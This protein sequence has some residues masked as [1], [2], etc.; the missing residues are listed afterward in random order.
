MSTLLAIGLANA[1]CAAVLAVPA[2]LVGRYGRRPALA[3]ALWLLVLLKLVTPPVVRPTL[4]WLP[5]EQGPA[6]TALIAA[7][8]RSVGMFD[9]PA[10]HVE[11]PTQASESHAS[12]G[13]SQSYVNVSAGSIDLP[14]QEAAG[15][16]ADSTDPNG[17]LSFLIVAWVVGA[18][19]C[20]ARVLL[21][22]ARFHR[23]LAYAQL[24]PDEM[25]DQARALARQMGIRH[26]PPVWLVPGSLP[27]MVWGVGPARI[28]F[29]AGLLDRLDADER[30]A[31]LAHELGHVARRDHMVR[32]LELA[33]MTVWWWF[34]LVWWARRQ[35]Q[36]REEEC[37]DA[38]AAQTVSARVYAAAI[39][40]TVDFLANDR[41][42]VPSVACPLEAAK[43]L[44]QR[45]LLIMTQQ[46]PCAL[47]GPMRMAVLAL[48]TCVAPLLPVLASADKMPV[49]TPSV[50]KL[51]DP[52]ERM[53]Q[54]PNPASTSSV[55][56][57]PDGK[58]IAA[59]SGGFGG[60]GE[61]DVWDVPSR[62]LIW[63]FPEALGIRSVKFTPDSKRLAWAGWGG[64]AR[65]ADLSA[66]EIVFKLKLESGSRL[67]FSPDQRWLATAAEQGPL[68][69]WE[70]STGR[71]AGTFKGD[72]LKVFSF[73]FSNDSRYL[74]A[75]GVK[76]NAP[77]IAHV[78]L[79]YDV[80][81]RQPVAKLTGHVNAVLNIAF[82]PRDTCIATSSADRT[83]RIWEGKSF[84][85]LNVLTGH[86]A[87]VGGLAFSPDGSMLATGSSDQS[88][89]FWDYRAGKQ[90]AQLQG[91]PAAVGELAFSP[92]GALLVS[93]G[94]QRSV[95]L[96][97]V[98]TRT[99]IATLL[100]GPIPARRA[101]RW[102]STT[103]RTLLER[104]EI[105]SVNRLNIGLLSC[106]L[107]M[108]VGSA[109]GAPPGTAD[110]YRGADEMAARIDHHIETAWKTAKVVPAGPASDAEF[111][112]RVYLDLAG[113]IP[114]VPE[115]RAFLAD[116]RTDR[117]QQLVESLLSGSRYVTH[118]TRVWRSLLL[119]EAGSNFQVRFQ[120][121]GFERW[122]RDWLLS[123]KGYDTMVRELLTVSVDGRRVRSL[124]GA[125]GGNPSAFYSA[126]EYKAEEIAAAASKLFLGVN[127]GCAQCHN[128]PF[129]SW[130]R[131]QFWSFAAFF[132]GIRFTRQGD[133]AV[134]QAELI[135]QHE[136]A[137]PGTDKKV[138]AKYLDG[139]V[140]KFEAGKMVRDTLAGWMTAKENPYFARATVNRMWAHFFGTG[141]I[142]PLE[143]M[144]GGDHLASHPG[145]L[146][147]LSRGFIAHDHDLKW[148]IRSIT[149]SRAYQ[150]TSSLLAP[151]P[152]RAEPVRA[153]GLARPDRRS[154][155]RQPGAGDRHS[156][157][158]GRPVSLRLRRRR[159]QGGVPD[160]VRQ[161]RRP[162]DRVA[163]IDPTS[164]DADERQADDHGH[165][166]Q[167][168]RNPGGHRRRTVHDH[169]GQG[170]SPL[171]RHPVA[172]ANFKGTV[173]DDILHRQDRRR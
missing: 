108:A 113:R 136:I 28:L 95:R 76:L 75:G 144:V 165:R 129:A 42:R 39:L 40:E 43:A 54:D 15:G 45:L 4:F 143:E 107:F 14:P 49:E 124:G 110:R 17:P 35:M 102:V 123:D 141:L 33:V 34:P 99:T 142:E 44:R 163:D 32:W 119:P 151:Q 161:R 16:G 21:Y 171:P 103:R 173:A 87:G 150:L 71:L 67:A 2:F 12:S 147:D 74:A 6:T 172:T 153:S 36:Q 84:K 81:S 126:K 112:R 90:I 77:S 166:P 94:P 154:T 89:R 79:I 73:A 63:Q 62:K 101:R 9:V 149:A 3:H 93:G 133:F 8:P 20:L 48:F 10:D 98:K 72:K 106:C 66:G 111:V 80:K 7:A 128:H 13:S 25:Q 160:Q 135:D 159:C 156:R 164:A 148:L 117:R 60:T 85:L 120:M 97:D 24:A 41:P 61:L 1:V 37:C 26:C 58:H 52:R 86:T 121:Q 31:L 157:G 130:K 146:D 78:A 5:A 100:R 83:V 134:A 158:R 118:F 23:L 167:D 115:V 69:M 55:A 68:R 170:R 122:L 138:K 65:V 29:P 116:R 168:E 18:V 152:G 155:L 19:A 51:A 50:E 139:T 47:S 114:T 11:P 57:S 105:A 140:P 109:S 70:A 96:W 169:A 125:E 64:I 46:T 59:G 56:F 38:W 27:P 137:I 92:D 162:A 30:A 53:T 132:S 131:E 145:L 82:A 104:K 88:I 127:L 22:A 91:P